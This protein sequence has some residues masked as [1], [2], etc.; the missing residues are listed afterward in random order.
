LGA[1]A[2]WAAIAPLGSASAA[3]TGT[4]SAATV[5]DA[6]FPGAP[7][8]FTHTVGATQAGTGDSPLAGFPTAAPSFGILTTG[9][10]ERA[11]T[12]NASPSSG[13]LLGITDP[14][15]GDAKDPITLEVDVTVPPGNSCLLVDYKFLSEEFPEFVGSQY[16]D[17]FIAELDTTNWSASGR[18]ISAPRDFAAGYGTQVSVNGVGP[19]EVSVANAAGTTYDAATAVLT[20]K[21]PA[22]PGPHS[23]FLSI[24]DASDHGYDSAVFLD[25]LRFNDEGPATCAAPDVFEGKVGASPGKEQ[26]TATGQDVITPIECN[27]PAAATAPCT[28]SV[29]ITAKIAG[30]TATIAR[31]VRLTRK[32]GYRVAPTRT[33]R[34]KLRLTRRGRGL[35]RRR[36]K[37]RGKLT[38]ANSINDVHKSFGVRIRKRG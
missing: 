35:L 2:A 9:N 17:A 26:L 7:G 20:T 24:F 33:R 25:E 13:A 18:R 28:G 11:D 16:N 3:V 6:I 19:T 27:L 32:R 23:V 14:S 10:A 12:P 22:A 38:I 34:M 36:G 37:V 1:I 8:S 29:E 30:V 21:T 5:A 4:D 15:R 31:K